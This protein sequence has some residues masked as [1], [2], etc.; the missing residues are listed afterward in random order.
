V[1]IPSISRRLQKI[2]LV[3]LTAAAA[4]L[5][6]SAAPAQEAQIKRLLESR[7]GIKVESVSKAALS[8][9]PGLYEVVSENGGDREIYYTDDKVTFLLTG[10]IIDI[11]TRRNI[12]QER[13]DKL[14]AIR[15][16]DLPLE[17]A[18]KQVRG[19]GK[20]VVAIF[21]DPFCPFCRRL[22][23]N[24]VSM[25]NV[26]IYT[27]LYPILRKDESPA[28]SSRIWC[29]PD[30]AKAYNDMMLRNREPSPVAVCRAPVD[31]WLALGQKLGISATP[32]SYVGSGARIIGARFDELQRLI[33]EPAR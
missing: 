17:L 33:D 16:E 9:M 26:T 19:N 4:M 1:P 20:R 24:M 23:Q 7:L 32:V 11:A 6:W 5:A 12:T 22:D 2:C 30:R 13:L 31:K 3:L 15:F 10:N 29:S 18:I 27:F 28:M 14:A 21:S 25:D 8:T